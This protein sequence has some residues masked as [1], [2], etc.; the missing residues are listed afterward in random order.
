MTRKNRWLTP[1]IDRKNNELG[2]LKNNVVWCCWG[3]NTF[4]SD[5]SE[6]TFY[7]LLENITWRQLH[8]RVFFE[9][10]RPTAKEPY[11]ASKDATCF[12]LYS[13]E[14]GEV[15]FGEISIFSLG[16]KIKLPKGYEAQ[17]RARSGLAYKHGI[18]LVNGIGSIDNDF[19]G[20]ML[21]MLTTCLNKYK[22]K[23]FQIK[24]GDRI[25]QLT[26]QKVPKYSF[27]EGKVENDTQRGEGGF[28]S[29]GN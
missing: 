21:V 6:S 8:K 7:D 2:Y 1:S 14:S 5:L 19:R 17:V 26:I 13:V 4:K 10:I 15:R 27:V 9:K 3:V 18:M 28:G 29:T 22:D 24:A 11:R 12:D 23:G 20:E 25:A 16:I